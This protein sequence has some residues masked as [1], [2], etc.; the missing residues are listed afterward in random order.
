VAS[1]VNL[2]D[3]GRRAR[4]ARMVRR[5]TL[6][7]VVSRADFT[8]S[9]LS[10]LEN[11][12]LSP[13]LEGLVKLAQVLECG[14]DALVE[15]LSVPPR[16]VVMKAGNGRME[17]RRNGRAGSTNEYLADEWRGRSM[18][19]VILHVSGGQSHRDV[20]SKDGQ[21]FLIV[22][23]GA[24]QVE[25]GQEFI[26]LSQGDS[27]YIDATIPHSITTSGRK[28]A[29]VLSVSH[30]PH[31]QPTGTQTHNGHLHETETPTGRPA[32]KARS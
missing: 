25:Y 10:K 2:V 12:Q 17:N 26:L 13:S 5:L 18:D 14:V 4:A 9:W 21:R 22:L 27:I 8:I 28:K 15:G 7:D 6:E 24:V 29:R 16:H 19:P 32:A 1:I 11:G 20:E 3:L 30:A 23:E 31:A